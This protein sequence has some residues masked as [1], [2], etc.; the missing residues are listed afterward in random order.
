[1]GFSRGSWIGSGLCG[2]ASIT[3]LTSRGSVLIGS[4]IFVDGSSLMSGLLAGNAASLFSCGEMLLELL[5]LS[6][7]L[8]L[9][10]CNKTKNNCYFITHPLK[11]I[12]YH[13]KIWLFV[14]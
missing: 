9:F 4:S 11:N 5:S 8:K 14:V 1:M 7:D 12:D 10:S 13:N 6:G 3:G 2:C